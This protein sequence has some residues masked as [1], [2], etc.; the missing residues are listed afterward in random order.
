M[1]IGAILVL[2]KIVQYLT[3]AIRSQVVLVWAMEIRG[4]Y[5]VPFTRVAYFYAVNHAE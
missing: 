2:V 4:H 5:S 1:N 3:A